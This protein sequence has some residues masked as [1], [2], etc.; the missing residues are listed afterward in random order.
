MKGDDGSVTVVLA[1][2]I[3]LMAV[4][5]AC[6]GGLVQIQ[7]ARETVQVAAD[8]A[9]LAAAPVTFRPFGASGSAIEEAARFAAA[10]GGTLIECTGCETD[11]SWRSRVVRVEVAVEVNVLGLGSITVA[12]VSAAEFDPVGLLGSS[13]AGD[14]TR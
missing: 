9:A 5:A 7:L 11:A 13:A 3:G 14:P 8:S 2:V 12:A 6:I 10:N 1:A 4:L